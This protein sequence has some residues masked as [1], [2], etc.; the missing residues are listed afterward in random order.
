M[1][2]ENKA[3]RSPQPVRRPREHSHPPLSRAFAASGRVPVLRLPAA[4]LPIRQPLDGDRHETTWG[5]AAPAALMARL[6]IC[7]SPILVP[8]TTFVR[9][10]PL[11]RK[12]GALPDGGRG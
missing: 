9:R 5:Q 10:K 6:M 4:T 1:T 2:T 7:A 11:C 12:L 8:A 3:I